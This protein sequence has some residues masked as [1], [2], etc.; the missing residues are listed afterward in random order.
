VPL[1]PVRRHSAPPPFSPA[2]ATA[3]TEQPEPIGQVYGECSGRSQ[4]AP[5][6]V[7]NYPSRFKHL[8]LDQPVSATTVRSTGAFLPC[9]GYRA[10][11]SHRAAL[12][13]AGRARG[14]PNSS[15]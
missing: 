6:Q 2:V 11:G 13:R 14:W 4:E 5:R 3:L 1:G 10:N 8:T 7:S 12:H 15:T 9:P